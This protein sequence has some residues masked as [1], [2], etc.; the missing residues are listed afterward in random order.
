M[1][2]SKKLPRD[3]GKEE[4]KIKRRRRDQTPV[5]RM[6]ICF[7]ECVCVFARLVSVSVSV[8]VCVCFVLGNVAKETMEW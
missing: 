3:E 7:S 4:E 8:S 6:D 1:Q 5:D 2:P